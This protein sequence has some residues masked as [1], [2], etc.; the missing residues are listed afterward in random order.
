MNSTP[1]NALLLTVLL[2]VVAL[3]VC[4]GCA[5]VPVPAKRDPIAGRKT[6]DFGFLRNGKLTRSDVVAK[7]GASNYDFSDIRVTVYSIT[8]VQPRGLF[9]ITVVPAGTVTR[10]RTEL[11]I[12][13][14]EFDEQDRVKR[15]T[16]LTTTKHPREAAVNWLAGKSP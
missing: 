3:F 5:T 16:I 12:A 7:L 11:Q 6:G 13:L 1:K 9:L 15:S 8:T 2:A 14:I 10:G 4:P